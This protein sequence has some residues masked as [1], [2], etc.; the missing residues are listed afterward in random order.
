MGLMRVLQ[1]KPAHVLLARRHRQ[2]ESPTARGLENRIGREGHTVV[3]RAEKVRAD[4][5]GFDR[6]VI[7]LKDQQVGLGVQERALDD[8]RADDLLDV[9]A[10]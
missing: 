2:H 9:F 3:F 1:L 10:F 8:R 6:F 7:E 4:A 5:G